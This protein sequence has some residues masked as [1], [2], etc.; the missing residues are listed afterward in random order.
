[1]TNEDGTKSK[2]PIGKIEFRNS[3]GE[4]QDFTPD[5]EWDCKSNEPTKAVYIPTCKNNDKF[6]S[7]FECPVQYK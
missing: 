7:K 6:K 4:P 3:R 2:K 5:P 1:V